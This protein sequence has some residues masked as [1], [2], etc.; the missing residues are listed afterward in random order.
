[1]KRILITGEESYVGTHVAAYLA[2]WPQAYRTDTLSVR[3]EDWKSASFRGYDAVL[4]VAGIVHQRKTK[5]D[6]QQYPLYRQVNGLLPAAVAEKA[7][8]EGVGLFLFMSTE[9]VYGLT[10]KVGQTVTITRD[11]PLRPKDNYGKSKLEAEKLLEALAG[12]HFLVA[13]LRPPMI[14]GRGCKGNYGSLSRLA[15]SAPVFPRV[16]SRRS[17]LYIENFAAFVKG[18]IDEPQGGVFCPQDRAYVDVGEMARLI[19]QAHGRKLRLIPGCAWALRLLA[20]F[21]SAVNKAFGSLVYDRSL[22]DGRGDYWV[23]DLE[24]AIA[25]TEG[26][27]SD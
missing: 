23:K 14:Y 6:P 25:E 16:P 13:I 10:A 9:S 21:V 7:R 4:H 2:Q 11:T 19:A 17:M 18:L 22:S 8:S 3:G 12:D 5:D 1:M 26:E 20:P 24:N 15:R 27:E